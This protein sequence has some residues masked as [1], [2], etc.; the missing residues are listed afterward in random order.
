MRLVWV[1]Y[2]ETRSVVVY[3]ASGAARVLSEHDVLDGGDVLPG[4]SC[5]I[6]FTSSSRRTG[7]LAPVFAGSVKRMSP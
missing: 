4:F 2:P 1:L 7:S 3:R 5:A 6:L